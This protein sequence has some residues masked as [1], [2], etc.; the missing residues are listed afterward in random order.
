MRY[1][2]WDDVLGLE[3][4][5]AE[6]N[7]EA[8][9]I[10]I[11]AGI[12]DYTV[13]NGKPVGYLPSDTVMRHSLDELSGGDFVQM[14][15]YTLC[16]VVCDRL[17]YKDGRGWVYST[18]THLEHRGQRRGNGYECER[19]RLS[20]SCPILPLPQ[21][22]VLAL[23]RFLVRDNKRLKGINI[24][25]GYMGVG[26]SN[27]SGFQENW[28]KQ[29]VYSLE[30]LDGRDFIWVEGVS[31]RAL[32]NDV[33]HLCYTDKNGEPQVYTLD[34]REVSHTVRGDDVAYDTVSATE[35]YL[36]RK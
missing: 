2:S 21:E 20:F 19:A 15:D 22:E 1:L 27:T 18:G 29:R 36:M 12:Y 28:D 24:I 32:V 9:G 35:I 30:E 16:A 14:G 13:K 34:Y 4:F 23:D 11:E 5:L 8:I 26:G 33:L 31:L 3:K 6:D 7:D 10:E 25:P 17:Y